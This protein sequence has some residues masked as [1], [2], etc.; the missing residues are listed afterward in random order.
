MA[1]HRPTRRRKSLEPALACSISASCRKCCLLHRPLQ[2]SPQRAEPAVS[3]PGDWRPGAGELAARASPSATSHQRQ[4]SEHHGTWQKKTGGG[5][6]R[7]QTSRNV[8][9]DLTKTRQGT[10]VVGLAHEREHK[11]QPATRSQLRIC[12][13]HPSYLA[14]VGVRQAPRGCR[15][16][17]RPKPGRPTG[18]PRPLTDQ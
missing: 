13:A 12:P 9:R 16:A 11:S 18:A 8:R 5:V 17:L 3:R 14:G 2:W 10:E 15:R 1:A 7:R 4:A 6:Q